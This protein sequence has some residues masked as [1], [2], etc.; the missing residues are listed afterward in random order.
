MRPKETIGRFDQYL[1]ERGLSFEAVVIGGTALGLLGITTRE[2]RDCD[3]L[4]PQVPQEVLDAAREFASEVTAEA[5][6]LREDWLNDGPSSLIDVLPEGWQEQTEVIFKG[7][8]IT[9]R[10]LGRLDLLRSKL[11]ALCDRA[12]DLPDC[13]ALNPTA[14]ELDEI[15]PWLSEQ[16]T[17]PGWPD[18]VQGTLEDLKRRLGRG[19]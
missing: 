16:D 7:Q 10:C 15:E 5:A 1:H 19:L 2:T 4:H 11:F 14:A 17:N 3:V 9:L 6:V 12:L 13:L 8:S 18:H